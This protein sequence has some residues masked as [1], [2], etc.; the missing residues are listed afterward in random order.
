MAR[1]TIVQT[2]DDLAK[3][4]RNVVDVL[5]K[6]REPNAGDD[7]SI[8]QDAAVKRF[9]IAYE[10]LAKLMFMVVKDQAEP[11]ASIIDVTYADAHRKWHAFGY[12]QASL[13]TYTVWRSARN[14]SIHTYRP[15]VYFDKI[16]PLLDEFVTELTH[17]A[18][19]LTTLYA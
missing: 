4:T 13:V 16:E 10:L 15:E 17:V 3:A 7:V 11:E 12:G 5:G 8:L 14:V 1:R 19:R 18:D 2:I 6:L 9:E